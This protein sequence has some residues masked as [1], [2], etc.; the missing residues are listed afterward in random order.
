[1]LAISVFSLHNKLF[2]QRGL[3][4]KDIPWELKWERRMTVGALAVIGLAFLLSLIADGYE[5]NRL[6]NEEGD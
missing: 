1:L 4:V 5:L 2:T 6:I 3:D